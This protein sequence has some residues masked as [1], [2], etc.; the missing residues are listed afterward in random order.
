MADLS[1]IL[2]GLFTEIAIL[3]H[4]TRNRFEKNQDDAGLS[5]RQFGVLNYFARTHSD[6][7]SV[8]GIAWAFQIS[9]A[10]MLETV[11]ALAAHGYVALTKGIT[12]RDTVAA[13]TAAGMDARMEQLATMGPEI[14]SLV[15]EIPEED[16]ATAYRVLREI[17]LVF[18]NLPDR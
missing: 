14:G 8:S 12:P 11:D 2:P 15:S 1:T 10:E 13:I 6:P 4:L 18:D 16:L 9:E 17:R 5:L 7:D 3:E